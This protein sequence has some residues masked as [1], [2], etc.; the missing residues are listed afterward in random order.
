MILAWYHDVF[1]WL[2]TGIYNFVSYAYNVFLILSSK[3]IFN[4]G[5]YQRLVSNVYT[6][7]SIVVLFIVAYTFLTYIVDP[8]K[9]KGGSSTE[10]TIKGIFISFIMI[11]LCPYVFSFAYEV[12]ERVLMDGVI[13]RFFS[14]SNSDVSYADSDDYKQG[15][16]TMA[17]QTFSAFFLP[18]GTLTSTEIINKSKVLSGPWKLKNGTQVDCRSKNN[19]SC[20]LANVVEYASESG[21][22]T[23]FH[24]FSDNIDKGEIDYSWLVCLIA[25]G[26]LVYVLVSFCFDLAVRVCKLAF[27]QIIAPLCIACRIIPNKDSIYKNWFKATTNTFLVVFI[28]VFIMHLGIYLIGVLNKNVGSMFS[29]SSY[30][31]LVGTNLIAY[32]FLILGIVTFIKAAP[33]LIQDVFGIGDVKLGIRDK[34][35]EGFTL[36]PGAYAAMGAVGGAVTTGVRN[37]K[38]ARQDYNGQGFRGFAK[39]AASTIAGASSGLVHGAASNLDSKNWKDLVTGTSKGIN[40]AIENRDERDNRNTRYTANGGQVKGRLHDIGSTI[41]DWA[42][43]GAS[44][45][46]HIIKI[47][48][49]AK[50][51]FDAQDAEAKKLLDKNISDFALIAGLNGTAIFKGD[52]AGT[53]T[54]KLTEFQNQNMSLGAISQYIANEK[55]RST[56]TWGE[57]QKQQHAK[58]LA[59]YESMYNQLYKATAQR[60]STYAHN[61]VALGG[62][63]VE[64]Y[65]DIRKKQA[66]FEVF[67]QA[68]GADVKGINPNNYGKA[69]DDIAT[70]FQKRGNEAGVQ[71]ARLRA[72]AEARKGDSKK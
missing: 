59:M 69:I 41:A 39:G 67:A 5:D 1:L 40:K 3:N 72:E 7:L 71:S 63:G 49:Q 4:D 31:A 54:M 65:G 11:I 46:E 34:F 68:Q 23:G 25:G 10:K 24:A 35:K 18:T 15:G 21:K 70:E 17:A 48:E 33:K 47:G 38:K 51:K 2:A 57:A 13:G 45:Y 56:D 62:I 58:E 60:I 43:G 19:N 64:K 61:N 53:M 50:T 32:A 30:K 20:T 42:S 12:Q 9:D 66:E 55:A 28:R 22:F 8:E 6:I 44:Q 29:S 52:D 26:Y 27:Y 14:S 16:A 37:Y 36:T